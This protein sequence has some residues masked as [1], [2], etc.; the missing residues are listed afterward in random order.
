[1]LMRQKARAQSSYLFS[2]DPS[3][4]MT[5][6]EFQ[7]C[8]R[9]SNDKE[10]VNRISRASET[11]RGTRPYWRS[12]RCKLE[13]VVHQINSPHLFFTWS[14]ADIQWDDLHRHLP[15][16]IEPLDFVSNPN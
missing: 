11:L 9:E 8:I 2:K 5:L 15:K 6:E 12:Q 7:E 16:Y 10:L 1:M 13:A 14:A 3:R 4:D